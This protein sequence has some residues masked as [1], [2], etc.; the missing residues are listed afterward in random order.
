MSSQALRVE[1]PLCVANA[2][3]DVIA[4]RVLASLPHAV[5]RREHRRIS[6]VSDGD[7]IC[8][9]GPR[10][11]QIV[12]TRLEAKTSV[13]EPWLFKVAR[14]ISILA[15]QRQPLL[16]GPRKTIRVERDFDLEKI[17][18]HDAAYTRAAETDHHRR[19]RPARQRAIPHTTIAAPPTEAATKNVISPAMTYSSTS[20]L[21]DK[22][23]A[24]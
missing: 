20:T 7:S 10:T 3:G 17:A 1:Q 5:A 9:R 12:V 24:P 18:V 14:E 2:F 4:S 13:L 16:V 6:P 23:P 8:N 15:K 21:R 19:P 22:R 11:L